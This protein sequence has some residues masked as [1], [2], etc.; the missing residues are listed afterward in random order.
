MRSLQK[1]NED[2]KKLL[3]PKA[4]IHFYTRKDKLW[5]CD[6]TKELGLGAVN[7]GTVT[8]N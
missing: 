4:D 8:R 7:C 1:E 3:G 5:E 6:K 2:L